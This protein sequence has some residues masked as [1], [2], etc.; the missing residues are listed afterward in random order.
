MPLLDALRALTEFE[1]PPELPPCDL[2]EL[3]DVLD[4]HGLAPLASHHLESRRLGAAVPMPVRERLLAVYQGVVNDNVF[5][6]MTLKGALRAVE[7]PAVVL[8][9]AAW[10]D[11]LYPH[12]AFRPVGELR[13]AVR[14]EDGARFAAGVAPAGF[15]PAGRGKGGH[16][17]AFSDG[18]IEIGIQEGLVAGRPED[19]GLFGR[20]GPYRV[21]GPSAQRPAAE[22]ALLLCVADAARQG[23]QAPLL[24][25]LDMR[26]I[27]LR[28][29]PAAD[30]AV[31]GRAA[32][33]GLSRALHG[34]LG[35]VAHYWP[36]L[37]PRAAALEPEL[38]GAERAAVDAVAEP[39]R[40]PTRL[41]RLRGAEE[42]ARLLLSP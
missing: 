19:H 11:W 5:R 20:A 34:A 37:A 6:M 33:A 26:E 38:S 2:G 16:T 42:A 21:I 8:G 7:A 9:G 3:A 22:D 13:L 10:L 32:E 28:L 4:A 14:G 25:W 39:V 40:D 12:L 31:R 18:R 24:A 41:R 1:P 36:R 23:L 15:E 35:L 29:E 30:A 17:A 27:L